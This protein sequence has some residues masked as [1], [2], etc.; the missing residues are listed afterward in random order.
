MLASA[1]ATVRTARDVANRQTDR[2]LLF[3]A[4]Q[5]GT[6]YAQRRARRTVPRVIRGTAVSSG[7]VA[8]VAVGTGIAV[9]RH[10]LALHDGNGHRDRDPAA[11]APPAP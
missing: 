11:V 7:L 10:R 3:I 4:L 5:S 8:A 6:W 1:D 9:V 2:L